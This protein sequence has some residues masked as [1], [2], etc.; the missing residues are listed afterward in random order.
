MQCRL[1]TPANYGKAYS[2]AVADHPSSG[3]GEGSGRG[4]SHAGRVSA[5]VPIAHSDPEYLLD[6]STNLPEHEQVQ[7]FP[8]RVAIVLHGQRF[9]EHSLEVPVKICFHR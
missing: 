6:G 4:P 5:P 1:Y 3:T 7:D 2:S 9:I 8:E